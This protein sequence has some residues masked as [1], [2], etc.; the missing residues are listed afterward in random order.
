MQHDSA[1]S[2]SVCLDVSG[3]WFV[4]NWTKLNVISALMLTADP[5]CVPASA[6]DTRHSCEDV[7]VHW[8]SQITYWMIYFCLSHGLFLLCITET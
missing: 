6:S 3:C 4:L 1:A 7:L 8:L 5:Q 2:S